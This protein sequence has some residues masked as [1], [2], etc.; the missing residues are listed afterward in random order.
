MTTSVIEMANG[1]FALKLTQLVLWVAC[2]LI[3]ALIMIF[4]MSLGFGSYDMSVAEA[5]KVLWA[6]EEGTQ[7]TVVWKLR[8][9]RF[10]AAC[11]VGAMFALS[12]AML[13]N[14][15][16][17]PIA[18]PS[19]VGVSQGASLAV[20]T[21]IVLWPD[22]P[23][24][25]RP[26]AA[27]AGGMSAALLVQAIAAGKQSTASMRFI[28][29]GIGVA[30]MISAGTSA[31]LAYGNIN[32]AMGAL[33]WLAGSVH[34]VTW[35]TCYILGLC[36]AVCLPAVVWSA[37]PMAAFQFGPEV[38]ISFGVRV[39]RDRFLVITLAVGLAAFAVSAA[40]PMGFIGL[41]APQLAQRL[42]PS[43]TGG[44]LVLSALTGGVLVSG[45][46]LIGRTI[47]APIQFPA[48][49]VSAVLGVPL[50]IFLIIQRAKTSQL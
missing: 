38:A 8:I 15:T 40:G 10:V 37:R 48:G 25:A 32:Q 13:Q 11:L 19:L 3:G 36:F 4:A 18:D 28:L 42:A 22:V 43:G 31:M 24:G 35:T 45:A 7:A 39:R 33:G 1:R 12:G 21:L 46:D 2:G 20:V 49:L 17:N 34:T 30:A 16:R 6:P 9:P 14:V 29:V 27:F 26:I 44:R 41:L 5:F 50:F 23:L 47:A